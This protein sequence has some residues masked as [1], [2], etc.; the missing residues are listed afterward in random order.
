MSV[1]D[2]VLITGGDG[3]TGRHLS[4]Y[5]IDHNFNCYSLKSN[6]LDKESLSSEILDVR[7]DF[8][9]HLAAI[10]FTAEK[11]SELIYATNLIGTENLL[12]ALSRSPYHC[13]KLIIASSAAIYGN[14]N[15]EPF[16]ENILPMPVSHY[17]ISKLAMEHMC[18]NYN[19]E[20]PITITRP[21]N[22]TG[23]GQDINFLV[24][25]IVHAFKK[26]Y[27]SIEL[28]N[29][30]VYREFNDIRDVSE[31]Y[32]LLITKDHSIDYINVCSGKLIS[33]SDI[34]S[35]M[36]VISN[37]KFEVNIN[38]DFV[39]ENEI[40]KLC[41]DPSKLHN[42]LKFNPKYNLDNTLQWMFNG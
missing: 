11:N 21:F 14:Q 4:K 24:P 34:I 29:I 28:G 23:L 37:T 17:G 8:V 36:E 19:K 22:Y 18:R 16:N 26:E 41:G 7:P 32:R 10:S 1:N 5:L 6:I 30:D 15:K 9:I 42:I 20:L 2:L 13:K 40:K 33:I 27:K 38:K 39:R 12:K 3:F 31:I 35:S 25:K